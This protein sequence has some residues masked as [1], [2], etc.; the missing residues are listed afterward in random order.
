M[1]LLSYMVKRVFLTIILSAGVTSVPLSSLH[2][3]TRVDISTQL[4]QSMLLT[5]AEFQQLLLKE[6]VD[7]LAKF[8]KS[9]SPQKLQQLFSLENPLHF[10]LS[11]ADS[12]SAETLDVLVSFG[13]PLTSTAE[14]NALHFV[15][16]FSDIE[17]NLHCINKLIALGVD[18]N[19]QDK[20]G[21]TPLV[22]LLYSQSEHTE[23]LLQYMLAKGAN[24]LVRSQS[25]MDFLHH[26][27][28]LQLLYSEQ[29]H[30]FNKD[31]PLYVA[32][33]NMVAIARSARS[34]YADFYAEQ[35][36]NRIQISAR[37]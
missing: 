30:Y 21:Y 20:D 28:A 12:Y 36:R 34:L 18:I 23:K 9:L 5:Q 10:L 1:G 13:A 16:Y 3:E 24:P 29:L 26:A 14:G 31:D 6:D 33:D 8:L 25:G 2:A 35:Q 37:K 19:L 32:A 11:N 17:D 15:G 22:K 4:M 27:L 7:G